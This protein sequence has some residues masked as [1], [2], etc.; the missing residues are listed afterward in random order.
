[1]ATKKKN[2]STNTLPLL[3]GAICFGIGAALM[4]YLYLKAKEAA[5][6]EELRGQE[7]RMV[8]VIVA[9]QNFKPWISSI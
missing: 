1:M 7:Q 6:E 4:G 8:R 3:I 9:K 5:L 2:N